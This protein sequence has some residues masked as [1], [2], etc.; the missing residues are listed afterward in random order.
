MPLVSPFPASSS[1]HSV[2]LSSR[3]AL[4]ASCLAY[5]F[6]LRIRWEGT[7]LRDNKLTREV[8]QT[9][10]SQH[11]LRGSSFPLHM[12]GRC[13]SALKRYYSLFQRLLFPE[14]VTWSCASLVIV[15]FVYYVGSVVRQHHATLHRY[16]RPH[17]SSFLLSSA[18]PSFWA[19]SKRSLIFTPVIQD[20]RAAI[21]HS[22]AFS[23]PFPILHY[24]FIVL[25]RHSFV[26][27]ATYIADG[28]T[29]PY[30]SFVS[31]RMRRRR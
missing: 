27:S 3:S 21:D 25:L 18:L 29:C 26:L 7:G 23:L 15:W 9:N 10:L 4:C 5:A 8:L 31:R 19:A 30:C 14:H 22:S 12:V 1:K 28:V 2:V 20:P 24:S 17:C 16:R 11:Y 6:H 13:M